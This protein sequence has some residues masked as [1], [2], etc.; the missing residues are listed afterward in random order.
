MNMNIQKSVHIQLLCFEPRGASIYT[1]RWLNVYEHLFKIQ[2][3]KERINVLLVVAERKR[4]V[5]LKI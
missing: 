2:V 4:Y 3:K 1:S 5:A